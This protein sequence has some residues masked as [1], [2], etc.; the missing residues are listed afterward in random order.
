[1]A[2]VIKTA[3]FITCLVVLTG[4]SFLAA[5]AFCSGSS[6]CLRFGS[7]VCCKFKECRDSCVGYD[8][9]VNSHCGGNNEYCCDKTCQ[10]G[11]C[12]LPA[13]IIVLMVL[14]VLGVVVTTVIL[15][16]CYFCSRRDKSSGLVV[17]TSGIPVVTSTYGAVYIH[18]QAS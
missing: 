5:E 9:V 8:C 1:M 18:S 15:V 12:G 3:F 16:L 4:E 6:D 2:V 13:W 14:S 17:S 10:N 7:K 11:D